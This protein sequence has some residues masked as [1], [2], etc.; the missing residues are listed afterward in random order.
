MQYIYS[1]SSRSH[2]MLRSRGGWLPRAVVVTSTLS[3]RGAL[4]G[5]AGPEQHTRRLRT[6]PLAG[7]GTAI[8]L[9][10]Q[11]E[12]PVLPLVDRLAWR[13]CLCLR[14]VRVLS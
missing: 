9:A 12:E 13:T 10:A 3:A 8:L 1:L 5:G 6:R 11:G 4:A 7:C 2:G 14:K